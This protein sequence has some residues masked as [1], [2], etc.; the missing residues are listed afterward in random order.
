MKSPLQPLFEANKAL[1]VALI[2]LIQVRKLGFA[3]VSVCDKGKFLKSYYLLRGTPSSFAKYLSAKP[4]KSGP[5][6]NFYPL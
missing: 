6:F 4:H 1:L 5:G 3:K 2:E